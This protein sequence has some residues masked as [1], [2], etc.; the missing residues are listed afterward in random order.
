MQVVFPG[1]TGCRDRPAHGGRF[2]I[3]GPGI[4]QMMSLVG[5]ALRAG[6]KVADAATAWGGMAV[7]DLLNPR[8]IVDG[9]GVDEWDPD[10][11]RRVLPVWRAVFGT[12]FR[13]EVRGL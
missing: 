12:Y 9:S 5:S 1:V 10:Y 11:I 7:D 3:R 6:A 13:G 4:T 8:R 2:H